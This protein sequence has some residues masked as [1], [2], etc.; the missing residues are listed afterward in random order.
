MLR[1]SKLY[2]FVAFIFIGVLFLNVFCNQPEQKTVIEEKVYLNHSDT[3]TYV[4][5]NKC[6]ECHADKFNS[7][8]QTGMG[9]SFD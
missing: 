4:G 6:K 9:L 5:M 3:V 2:I 7:F 8:A 1:A